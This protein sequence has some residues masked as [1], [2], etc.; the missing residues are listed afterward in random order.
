MPEGSETFSNG[1]KYVGEWR[2]D[3]KNGPGTETSANGKKDVREFY[4]NKLKILNFGKYYLKYI[5]L[6]NLKIISL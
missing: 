6:G 3:M 5:T 2:R 4:N 1:Y